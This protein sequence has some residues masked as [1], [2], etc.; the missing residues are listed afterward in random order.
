MDNHHL[1]LNNFLNQDLVLS[2]LKYLNIFSIN[3]IQKKN[4]AHL[5][6]SNN[7]LNGL[8]LQ[9]EKNEILNALN[10]KIN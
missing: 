8:K 9:I 5:A 6:S 4:K 2:L 10:Q 7:E 1:S 3:Y